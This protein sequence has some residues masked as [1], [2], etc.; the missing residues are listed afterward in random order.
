VQAKLRLSKQMMLSFDE[1]GSWMEPMQGYKLGSGTTWEHEFDPKREYVRHEPSNMDY[2]RR[3]DNCGDIVSALANA[4]TMLV[5]LRHADRIKIGC[6]TPGL[7][8]LAGI[9][10]DNVWKKAIHYPFTQ[11]MKYGRGTSLKTVIDCETYDV[12]GYALHHHFQYGDIEGVGYVDAASAFDED[13]DELNVFVI[14]RD[15]KGDTLVDLDV[16]GFSGYKLIEHIELYSDDIDAKNTFDNPD[17]VIP[18]I[19]TKTKLENGIVSSQLK[20]MS[21]NVFKLTK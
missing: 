20:A 15:W 13:K 11:L 8:A 5:L 19:N 14:N 12:P 17:V 16:T 10:K 1:Y 3:Y 4:S 9:N 18:K 21:W 2:A 7:P 6:M